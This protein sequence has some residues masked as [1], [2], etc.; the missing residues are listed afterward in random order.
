VGIPAAICLGV[1][2]HNVAVRRRFVAIELVAAAVTAVVLGATD[3]SASSFVAATAY[4]GLLVSLP[5]ALITAIGLY[6]TRARV[7]RGSRLIEA[8]ASLAAGW[9]LMLP[10]TLDGDDFVSRTCLVGQIG[11]GLVMTRLLRA[12]RA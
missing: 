4:L 10:V 2:G 7:D 3:D 1:I 8:W 5:M 9:V 6:A 11:A 12:Q